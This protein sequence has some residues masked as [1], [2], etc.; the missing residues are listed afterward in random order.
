MPQ[1]YR[2][3][4]PG[5]QSLLQSKDFG[6]EN[7]VRSRNQT[8]YCAF[9]FFFK[10]DIANPFMGLFKLYLFTLAVLALGCCADFSLVVWSSG[11]FLIVMCGLLFA[12]TSPGVE[13][14]LSVRGL[15]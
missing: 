6:S 15:L 2:S 11:Y 10:V 4:P 12:A 7:G 9:F 1:Y 3:L 14:R 8:R 5:T 13:H